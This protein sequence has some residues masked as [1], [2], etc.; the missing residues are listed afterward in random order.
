M[1]RAI[2]VYHACSVPKSL[3]QKNLDVFS[4]SK[5]TMKFPLGILII[6]SSAK[7]EI[8]FVACEIIVKWIRANFSS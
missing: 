4:F 2:F 8:M 5:F 6:V 7:S 3:S 1:G